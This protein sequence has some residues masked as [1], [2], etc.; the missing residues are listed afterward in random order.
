ML[1]YRAYD[2]VG[3]ALSEKLN[4]T[5]AGAKELMTTAYRESEGMP[6]HQSSHLNGQRAFRP[7]AS[8]TVLVEKTLFFARC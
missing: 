7:A 4:I 8:I 1:F 5:E 2:Y 6:V 3:G